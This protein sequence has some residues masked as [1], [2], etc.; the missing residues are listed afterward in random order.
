MLKA[1]WNNDVLNYPFEV[2]NIYKNY[3]GNIHSEN[4]I[5]KLVEDWLTV[6]LKSIA[7]GL[8]NIF[9]SVYI[10][11]KDRRWLNI[12]HQFQMSYVWKPLIKQTK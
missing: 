9:V 11:I 7:T 10:R 6:F 5:T 12:T 4:Q 1:E 3:S 8:M 2:Q